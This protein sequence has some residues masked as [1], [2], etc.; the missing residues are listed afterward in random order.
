M[1]ED[2]IQPFIHEDN[3]RVILLLENVSD[4]IGPMGQ[5]IVAIGS[6]NKHLR[7]V[8]EKLESNIEKVDI[9]L[10]KDIAVNHLILYGDG[11]KIKGLVY[12]FNAQE[13]ELIDMRNNSNKKDLL[14]YGDGDKNIGFIKQIDRLERSLA[15]WK[16]VLPIALV[17]IGTLFAVLSYFKK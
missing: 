15:F 4:Q 12:R 10:E 6:E 11:D 1:P 14:I 7:E 16:W 13:L 8:A 5:A 2:K 9:K 17:A 3:Q